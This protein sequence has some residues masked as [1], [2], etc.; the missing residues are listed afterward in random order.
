MDPLFL[1]KNSKPYN[2]KEKKASST[3]HAFLTRCLHVKYKKY[4]IYLPA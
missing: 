4:H 3:N 1:T 2:E